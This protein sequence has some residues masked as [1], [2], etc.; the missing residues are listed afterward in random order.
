MQLEIA[1]RG[2]YTV[3]V[4]GVMISKIVLFQIFLDDF[5]NI[6][7]GSVDCRCLPAGRCGIS[8]TM[9]CAVYSCLAHQIQGQ[10]EMIFSLRYRGY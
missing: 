2:N 5:E 8:P 1:M 9:Q 6:L 7:P 3:S 4:N 10:A